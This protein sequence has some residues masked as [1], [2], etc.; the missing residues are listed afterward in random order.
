MSAIATFAAAV[1]AAGLGSADVGSMNEPAL[2][3][4]TDAPVVLAKHGYFRR[5]LGLD[6]AYHRRHHPDADHDQHRARG[7][8]SNNAADIPAPAAIDVYCDDYSGD[9]FAVNRG[10]NFFT[11]DEGLYG[12]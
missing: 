7:F 4:T 5:D 3:G 2:Y 8:R 9:C 6:T 10:L 11:I 12:K 1:L